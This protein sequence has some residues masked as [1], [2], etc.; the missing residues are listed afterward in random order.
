[1]EHKLGEIFQYND[2]GNTV[3]LQIL[4]IASDFIAAKNEGISKDY[5]SGFMDVIN[6]IRV[7]IDYEQDE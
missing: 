6:A 4:D 3:T 1:M 5:H 7:L 2:E